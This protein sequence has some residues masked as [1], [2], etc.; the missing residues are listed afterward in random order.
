MSNELTRSE[1][2]NRILELRRAGFTYEAI[3]EVTGVPTTRLRK[4]VKEATESAGSL[5]I[6]EAGTLRALDN[7]R[8]EMMTAALWP[9]AQS[10]NI[11]AIHAV[12]KIQERRAK[13]L[14]LDLRPDAANEGQIA[15]VLPAWMAEQATAFSRTVPDRD[16]EEIEGEAL[17][18]I[19]EFAPRGY[20]GPP[21]DEGSW[22]MDEDP[23]G[24]PGA[25]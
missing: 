5:A 8:L 15:L 14:G 10:G 13:L 16:P 7:D 11:P 22:D 23:E 2:R 18:E 3:R 1:E 25:S 6:E 20:S 12:L 17:A 19:I 21:G 24:P 9:Q 4:I